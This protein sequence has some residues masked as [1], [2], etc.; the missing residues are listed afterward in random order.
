MTWPLSRFDTLALMGVMILLV[1]ALT[2]LLRP[3]VRVV[4]DP[5]ACTHYASPTGQGA[6]CT[7]SAPCPLQ[8]F[9]ESPTLAQ[10]GRVLCLLDGAYGDL[11]VPTT[12]NGTAQQ[13]IVLRALHDGKVRLGWGAGSRPVHLQGSYGVLAGVNIRGGDNATVRFYTNSSY[14][15]VQRVVVRG[16]GAPDSVVDLSG[17][18]N[19]IE[20]CAVFGVGRYSIGVTTSGV[21]NV[22]RRC[23]ARW[24][25]NQF[26]ES[27][28]TTAIIEGYGQ[29]DIVIENSI[30]T[31]TLAPGGRNTEPLGGASL[32]GTQRSKWLGSI[33][34]TQAGDVQPGSFYGLV[35]GGSHAQQG[36]FNPTTQL[37]FQHN[38]SFFDPAHSQFAGSQAYAFDE[39]SEPHCPAGTDNLIADSVGVSGQSSRFSASFP[40]RN[41][42]HGT[43]LAGAIGAGKSLW[44]DSVAAPGLCKQYVRGALTSLPLW[45][46]PMNQRLI[47]FMV[48]EGLEPVDVMATLQRL[49]G[50]IPAACRTDGPPAPGVDSTPPTVAVTA[51]RQGQVLT[52]PQVTVSADASDNVGVVGVQFLLDGVPL[53]S[54]DPTAPYTLTWSTAGVSAGQHTMSARARDQ[55]GNQATAAA[56]TFALAT[57]TPP[58]PEP[59]PVALTCTGDLLAAG[60]IEL[61]CQAHTRRR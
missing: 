42:Q 59:S 36:Q 53:H 61:Q 45:P 17:S 8:T 50:P 32:W 1:V 58:E 25:D 13:P 55:A 47:D 46:F 43:S 34:Y 37:V 20:D 3:T 30:S 24:E 57:I 26:T 7:Q 44:T 18:H 11:S 4:T 51:P 5:P 12:F 16:L 48:A 15:T 49:L 19:T 28:P 6:T 31:R 35:D 52:I 2:Y 29:N 23:W 56:I 60:R 33:F 40:T 22:V 38:V 27:N 14:W 10:P 54:E 21:G 39:C 9:V 41:L